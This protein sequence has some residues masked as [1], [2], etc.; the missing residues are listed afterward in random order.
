MSL[1][2]QIL[3]TLRRMFKILVGLK[4]TR[5]GEKMLISTRCIHDLMPNLIK[6]SWTDSK[7]EAMGENGGNFHTTR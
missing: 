6:K 1:K 3:Q 7:E 4:G 2:V 5:F